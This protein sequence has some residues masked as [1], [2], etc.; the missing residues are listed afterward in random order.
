VR[1]A[2]ASLE[3]E[4]VRSGGGSNSVSISNNGHSHSY[5]YSNSGNG[6]GSAYAYS[7]GG[8]SSAHTSGEHEAMLRKMEAEGLINRSKHYKIEKYSDRM[9]INNVLQPDDVF[10]RYKKYVHSEM[11]IIEGTKNSI[12][13]SSTTNK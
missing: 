6:N 4:N 5:V 12:S 11:L 7:G 8:S 2:Q 3:R 1:Q 13:I 9:Y 10:R